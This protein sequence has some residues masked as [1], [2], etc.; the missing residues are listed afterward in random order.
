MAYKNIED[1]R[2]AAREW[3]KKNPDKVKKYQEGWNEKRRN[4]DPAIR[5]RN[6]LLRRM[7]R[8]GR[9]EEEQIAFDKERQ[10]ASRDKYLAKN[11]PKSGKERYAA[12]KARM[13][14]DPE[15]AAHIKQKWKEARD[16]FRGKPDYETPEQA[17]KRRQRDREY[18][19]KKAREKKLMEATAELSKPKPPPPPKEPPKPK[20]S[21]RKKPGRLASLIMW[22]GF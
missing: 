1:A 3:N 15:Y 19:A 2:R 22:R 13:K 6:A 18:R 17:E 12:I 4:Q 16:R 9:T 10:Q 20:I 14:I 5:E 7:K 8:S 11:P 21:L